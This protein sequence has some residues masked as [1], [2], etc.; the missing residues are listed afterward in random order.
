MNVLYIEGGDTIRKVSSR[1]SDKYGVYLIYGINNN[2]EEMILYR[3][4]GIVKQNGKFHK[5]K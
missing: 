4:W 1:Y 3:S 5:Q 2:S